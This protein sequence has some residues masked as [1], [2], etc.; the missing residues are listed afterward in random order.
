MKK[1]I[2]IAGLIIFSWTN[3]KASELMT[4]ARQLGIGRVGVVA[5]ATVSTKEVDF[6]EFGEFDFVQAAY[7]VKGTF[8]VWEGWHVYA[9]VGKFT[10]D[11]ESVATSIKYENKDDFDGSMFGGGV[12]WVMFPDTLVTPAV[13]LDISVTQWDADINKFNVL[14]G[15]V[16]AD[17]AIKAT[18]I[19]GAVMVS[20]KLLMFDP[21]IGVK[22]INT[23]VDWKT[24]VSILG[25]NEDKEISGDAN[26]ISPFVG[27]KFSP[28]PF[29]SVVVEG[30]FAK[31]KNVSAGVRVGF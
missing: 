31:E 29:V 13:T 17:W 16:K 30:S 18:E 23:D 12:K 6:G 26:G 3:V 20:K 8:K 10:P 24:T 14:G 7:A 27:I 25:V 1:I 2:I 15:V 4:S 28:L 5:Y 21:Y 11:I 19:Q 22:V 9:K